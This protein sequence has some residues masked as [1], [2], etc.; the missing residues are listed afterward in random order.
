[1]NISPQNVVGNCTYKCDMA[2]NYPVKSCTVTNS[3]SYLNLSCS[4]SSS[5]VT[6][7]NTKYS[8]LG[9]FLGCPSLYLYNNQKANAELILTHYAADIGK[10]LYVCIPLSTNG[11]SGAASNKIAEIIDATAKGAP[12]Q[13]ENT[14]QGISDFT[15]NDFIPL[16]E[17]Y[18]YETNSSYFVAFGMQN[19]I[20][21]SQK[22]LTSLQKLIKPYSGVAFPS[23][24]NLFV[25]KKGP[26][27]GLNSTGT[28]DIY[29]DCQPTNSS[30]D[31]KNEVV[32]IKANT[33]Y[34][35]GSS[36]SNI[37]YN[38]IFLLILFAFAFLVL[39]VGINKG[40]KYLTGGS[41]DGNV[42]TS[43]S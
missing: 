22:S 1:M 13:G 26:V 25:N 7:N 21:I 39:I 17:F 12:S 8:I 33:A 37:L 3:G 35:V 2:F 14:S 4:D 34:D 20:Y 23:G 31:E 29:I 9:G 36:M 24:P 10:Q 28:N 32:N 43:T 16:K 11:T 15:L 30:E 19:A 41:S 5:P 38:P 27:K 42:G 6:F 40:L 18:S